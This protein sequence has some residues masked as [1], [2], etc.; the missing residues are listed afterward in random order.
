MANGAVPTELPPC[1]PKAP[2]EAEA[3]PSARSI[4]A[5][6]LERQSFYGPA[7]SAAD[8]DLLE[9]VAFHMEEHFDVK[10][11][12]FLLEHCPAFGELS[13]CPLHG[14]C[15]RVSCVGYGYAY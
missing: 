13:R 4:D 5:M 3:A 12:A 11:E 15:R 2:N 9:S 7:A 1:L 14:V 6:A 10:V 8:V